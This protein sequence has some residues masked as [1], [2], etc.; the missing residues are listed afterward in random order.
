MKDEEKL[1]EEEVRSVKEWQRVYTFRIVGLL[2]ELQ[3]KISES[4]CL[5]TRMEPSRFPDEGLS[6]NNAEM[7]QDQRLELGARGSR[8]D[9]T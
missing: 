4:G 3:T 2:S 5:C 8:R 1:R 6:E 9:V 7:G